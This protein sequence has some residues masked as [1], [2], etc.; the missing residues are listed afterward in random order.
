MNNILQKRIQELQFQN[1][2]LKE[3]LQKLQE[4]TKKDLAKANKKDLLELPS[5][6]GEQAHKKLHSTIVDFLKRK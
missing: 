4:V 1:A 2:Q 5:K 6:E 3:E